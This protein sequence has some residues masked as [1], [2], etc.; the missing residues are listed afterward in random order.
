V[1]AGYI[2]RVLP[3]RVL[4]GHIG[5]A[6][7]LKGEVRLTSFT[8]DPLAIASYG[9]L[10]SA[11]GKRRFV[12]TQASLRKDIIVARIQGVADRTGAEALVHQ[13]LWLPRDRLA[14]AVEED[15]FL[16][17]DLIGCSVVTAE[18]TLIG[19]VADVPNYGAGDLIEI[20]PVGGSITV[21]LPF[22]KVFAPVVEI[23]ARRIV[24]DPPDGF[25]DP[26]EA[27]PPDEPVE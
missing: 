14:L 15:E 7:G 23:A 18:G 16:L 3:D 8:Q 12:I 11:D 10:E 5:R 1:P 19:E 21:L 9:P 4:L 2:E 6:Q 27:A 22:T 24:I 20:M 13:E 17:S 26:P 25:L